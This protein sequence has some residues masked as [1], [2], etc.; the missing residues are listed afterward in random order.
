MRLLVPELA[1]IV[2]ILDLEI[3]VKARVGN[4]KKIKRINK[5]ADPQHPYIGI[6]RERNYSVVSA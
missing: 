2:K 6:S 3:K 4:R 1:M 5:R